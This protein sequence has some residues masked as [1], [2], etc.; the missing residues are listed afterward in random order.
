MGHHCLEDVSLINHH[1]HG[2]LRGSLSPTKPWAPE[3]ADCSHHILIF[4]AGEDRIPAPAKRA[5]FPSFCLS[6]LW[7]LTDWMCSTALVRLIYFAWSTSSNA[8]I[9][10]T[11]L[12]IFHQLSGHLLI[13]SSLHKVLTITAL[14]I[15]SDTFPT[16]QKFSIRI[17]KFQLIEV[18]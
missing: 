15:S 18:P 12:E 14:S 17:E 4:R 5:H 16:Y 6:V 8:N 7:T 13:L 1:W 3:P 2:F 11:H 9:F 10:Q